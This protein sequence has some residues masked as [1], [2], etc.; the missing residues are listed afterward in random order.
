MG[1]G[2]S[3]KFIFH[4]GGVMVSTKFENPLALHIVH[5]K[6]ESPSQLCPMK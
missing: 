5:L 3:H 6:P 4:L 2:V 1:G